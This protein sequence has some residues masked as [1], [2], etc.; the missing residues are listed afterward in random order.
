MSQS[1]PYRCRGGHI[2][3]VSLTID[4]VRVDVADG[5]SV[6]DAARIAGIDIPTLCTLQGKAPHPSCFLCMVRINGGPRLVPACGTMA[7]NGMC[8]ESETE[9]VISVRKTAIELLLSDHLGDCIG[10]CQEVCPAHLDTPK[11]L[12]QIAARQYRD[13]LMTV[14][15]TIPLPAVLGR[16]CPELCEKGCRRS[17]DDGP[18]AICKLKRF[19]ADEDLNS[20]APYI[21]AMA[22]ESGKRVAVVG[23]GPAGLSAAYYLLVQGHHCTVFD[24]HEEPGGMMRV[25]IPES[26]LPRDVL[27]AEIDLIR[28][29]GMEFQGSRRVGDSVSI[30][31]LRSD[32]DAVILAIGDVSVCGLPSTELAVSGKALSVDKKSMQTNLPGVFAAGSAVAP[33]HFAVRA[34]AD[35]RQAAASVNRYLSGVSPTRTDREFSVHIGKLTQIE[36]QPFMSGA[37]L[38][39]RA[40]PSSGDGFTEEEAVAEA[41]RCLHCECGKADTCALRAVALRLN[42]N[43]LQYREDRRTFSADRSNPYVWFE[44]GKCIACGICVRIAAE[45]NESLGMSY[46]GRGYGVR[47][48]VPFHQ[49]V[50]EGLTIAARE[51]AEACPTGALILRTEP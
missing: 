49:S 26:Q 8:V 35:G 38:E 21:P 7:Q 1:L 11:M 19:V 42:A 13:A 18:V 14:K 15:E 27:D 4:D 47:M 10:P 44:P 12:R 22:A 5:S 20:Q 6:L 39:L 3:S 32:F 2:V 9:D 31:Q 48:N 41:S 30:E 36:L 23:T 29:M 50:A 24:D 16:I 45:R 17:A 25:A 34:V 37:S 43:P 40:A 46:Q 51:C 33:S 28:R